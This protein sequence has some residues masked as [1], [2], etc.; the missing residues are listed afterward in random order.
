MQWWK[1]MFEDSST[2]EV[3]ADDEREALVRGD[4]LLDLTWRA[5]W[6]FQGRP[7]MMAVEAWPS[8]RPPD[9]LVFDGVGTALRQHTEALFALESWSLRE[10]V[11]TA[12]ELLR[13][14]A[15]CAR[16]RADLLPPD[17]DWARSASEVQL[18]RAAKL[19]AAMPAER[20]WQPDGEPSW[21]EARAA[22][23][24]EAELR[25]GW[26][27]THTSLACMVWD[28]V[29]G[30]MDLIAALRHRE[31]ALCVEL[32]ALMRPVVADLSADA[33]SVLPAHCLYLDELAAVDL[34]RMVRD[35]QGQYL[36]LMRGA[37]EVWQGWIVARPGFERLAMQ[38]VY[39][40]ARLDALRALED[41]ASK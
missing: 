15:V 19:L 11:W 17:V 6:G 8:D 21:D 10:D 3:C 2:L 38:A 31:S 1:V 39:S 30:M 26:D 37:V 5:V 24:C 25:R 20:I 34:E 14:Q 4:A 29:T 22:L 41:L 9:T 12:Y 7:H 16:L 28:R 13:T 36:Q 40:A 23:S 33:W 35:G 18:D 32:E 27:D